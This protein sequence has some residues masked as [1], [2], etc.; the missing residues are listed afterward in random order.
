MPPEDNPGP[1]E[2]PI[3][4]LVTKARGEHAA[5]REWGLLKRTGSVS[6]V[7]PRPALTRFFSQRKEKWDCDSFCSF[8]KGKWSYY[9]AQKREVSHL[10]KKQGWES[11]L[12]PQVDLVPLFCVPKPLLPA[13]LGP[14]GKAEKEP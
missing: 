5:A 6:A 7:Q 4:P 3:P 13:H 8:P 12:V 1:S 9:L 11:P 14:S 2:H 10:N